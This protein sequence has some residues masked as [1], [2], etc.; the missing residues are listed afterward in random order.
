MSKAIINGKLY[1]TEKAEKV[2]SF[3]RRVDM[4]PIYSGSEIHYTPLHDIDI[5]KTAK[6]NYFEHDVD[7]GT[8]TTTDEDEVK[9]IIRRLYPDKYIE[10]FGEVEEA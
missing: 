6:G 7:K 4:G 5:Y 1:D 9:D 3:R 10:L 2:V 8:I